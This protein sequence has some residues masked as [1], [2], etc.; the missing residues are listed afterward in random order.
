MSRFAPETWQEAA[1][2]PLALASPEA[3]VYVEFF[4]PDFRFVFILLLLAACLLLRRR[5]PPGLRPVL[6]LALFIA[7]AFAAWL[8]TSA[9]GRYFVPV[10]AAGRAAGRGPG[11]LAACDPPAARGRAGGHGAVATVPPAPDAPPGASGAWPSGEL[12][13]H[14]GSKS[15]PRGSASPRPTSPCPRCRTPS[16]P[17]EFHPDSRWINLSELEGAPPRVLRQVEAFL[18]QGGPLR[19]IFPTPGPVPP[20]AALGPCAR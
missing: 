19:V 12:P 5:V 15:R 6:A 16:S 18:D 11:A 8:A 2:R 10:S 17:P 9:N 3:G 13:P 7:L 14:S 1:L 4:A 20:T